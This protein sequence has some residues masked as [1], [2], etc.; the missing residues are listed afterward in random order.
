MNISKTLFIAMAF[1]LGLSGCGFGEKYPHATLE[2][3]G[4]SVLNCIVN[5][6]KEGLRGLVPTKTDLQK[7]LAESDASQEKKDRFE[8][9]LDE[10]WA[11]LE[12]DMEIEIFEGF[13]A[14]V[15]EL[16]KKIDLSTVV[17]KEMEVRNR[18]KDAF[19]EVADLRVRFASSAGDLTL[20]LDE[21]AKVSSGWVMSPEGF[22]V[23]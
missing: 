23:E 12:R 18:E 14:S 10:D 4:E 13:E 16:D 2:E 15:A 7:A 21:C 9:R 11:K 17:L 22:D 5:K 19:F 20:R 1:V 8:K 3:L 6:D